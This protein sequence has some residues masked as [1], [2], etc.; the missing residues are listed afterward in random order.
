MLEMRKDFGLKRVAG[1]V[2]AGWMLSLAAGPT[3][4]GVTPRATDPYVGAIVID[5]DSGEVLYE[6]H[7]DAMGYP[8]SVLKLMD[9]L[10]VLDAVEQGVLRLDDIVHVDAEAAGMGGS[11]V[12]LA[13]GEAFSVDEL[14]YA[15]MIQSA[16]DVAT[17]LAKRVA[18]SKDGFVK[19]MNRRA[20]T[21][22]MKHTRFHSVHGLPPGAG[23][24]PDITTARDL[25]T[26]CREMVKRPEVFRYTTVKE[27]GFRNGEFIMRTH[28]PLLGQFEGCDGLKTGFYRA[29]G[30]S[31]AATAKRGNRRLIA[32]VLGSKEKKVR[33]AKV[34]EILSMGFLAAGGNRE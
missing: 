7:A 19:L 2:C 20:A 29:A 31:I 15:L 25:A 10:L 1:A 16:N 13:E 22:G 32:V 27:R 6:D 21:L 26:L 14:L 18:G 5:A 30:F 12:Y 24:V 17:A 23:Q 34:R 33:N 28:N 4:A 9:L 11:Q 3:W 8:A